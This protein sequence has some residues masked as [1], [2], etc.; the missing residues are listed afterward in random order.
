MSIVSAIR[1]SRI[2]GT[3]FLTLG[4]FWG[5]FAAQVPTLKAG[6]GA[7]DSVFGTLLLGSALGVVSAMVLAPRIDR[8]L[9]A[10]GMQVAAVAIALAMILPGLVG[11]VW[12]FFGVMVCVGFAAGLLD[13]LMNTRVSDLEAA[14]G[15]TL[16]NA[17]HGLFSLGYA[18]GALL[19]GF[20]REAGWP[21]VAIFGCFA[22][23]ML[24][25]ATR[26]RMAPAAEAE[27]DAAD[28]SSPLWPVVLCGLVILLAFGSEATVEAW[29]ALHIERTLHGGAAEGALGPATLGLTMA[30]GRFSGQVVSDRFRD[31]HVI[32]VAALLSGIG[33]AIASVAQSPAM[34]YVGFGV[35]GLGVSVIGPLALAIVG[36][37][38]S[39]RQRGLAISRVA[40][41][42]FSAFFFAPVLM[43][44]SSELWGLRVSYAG[45]AAVVLLIV[46]LALA[47]SALQDRRAASRA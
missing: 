32:I 14:S 30:L 4:L 36:R 17:N 29:S 26:L 23:V 5:C 16:M 13:I 34:A 38:V 9:G 22:V 31:T 45:V 21:P 24:I 40:I 3:A 43:G 6:L 47:L 7:S 8:L 19:T 39:A 12:L 46:P 28:V 41:I 35:L 18:I 20:G 11:Q 2:P 33:A 37:L 15:R 10:R 1:L 42:G 27:Q 44:W 25:I